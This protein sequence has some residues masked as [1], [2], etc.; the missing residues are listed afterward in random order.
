LSGPDADAI[1]QDVKLS[2]ILSWGLKKNGSDPGEARAPKDRRQA[3]RRL[4]G[5]AGWIYWASEAG[6]VQRLRA[7]FVDSSQEPSGL[8]FVLPRMIQEKTIC[9]VLPDGAAALPCE[10]RHVAKMEQGF[11]V[12]ANLEFR[13]RILDGRSKSRLQWVDADHNVVSAPAA[14]KNSGQGLIEVSLPINVPARQ[15]VL[16]EGPTYGCLAVCRGARPDG[17]RFILV[18]EAASD[19][20]LTSAAA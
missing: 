13:E 11:R 20:F 15:T 14:V 5:G 19:S 2:D 16:L 12:G 6:D 18:V 1:L 7:S 4:A 3:V 8:G 9:W 17:N 10:V